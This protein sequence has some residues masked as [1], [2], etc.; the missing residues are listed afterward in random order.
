MENYHN[1]TNSNVK[2]LRE[3]KNIP[4]NKMAEQLKIDQSTLAK[5]ENNTRQITLDWCI[6]LAKYFDV[7]IGDFISKDLSLQTD[8][9]KTLNLSKEEEIKVINDLFR[10]KGF[11]NKN[12]ELS[13]ETF[14]ELI[15]F[16]IA[17]K[18]YIMKDKK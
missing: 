6:K 17:N 5:W 16:A 9:N 12:E 13:K 11:L 3:N 8:E 2:Y 4:Q 14:D 15:D 10:K 7:F 1:Y 18:K